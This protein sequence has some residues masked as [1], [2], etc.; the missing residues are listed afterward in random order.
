MVAAD[1]SPMMSM[2]LWQKDMGIISEFVAAANSPSPVFDQ[3]RALYSMAYQDGHGDLDSSVIHLLLRSMSAQ[4][5]AEK[6]SPCPG[7]LVESKC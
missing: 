7:G 5:A 1:Y 4:P 2:H 6:S 3:A